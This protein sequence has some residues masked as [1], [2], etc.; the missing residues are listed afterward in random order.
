MRE[1]PKEL[2][3][4]TQTELNWDFKVSTIG[5]HRIQR[6]MDGWMDT[7]NLELLR[8]TF[9]FS[10]IFFRLLNPFL[11]CTSPHM[12]ILLR[13]IHSSLHFC[14]KAKMICPILFS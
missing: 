7:L 2:I 13:Q 11:L 5:L 10:Q 1:M 9:S 4:N 14:M 8:L 12:Q 3:K 6:R